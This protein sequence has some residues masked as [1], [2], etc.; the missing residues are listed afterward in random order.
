MTPW[1]LTL[2]SPSTPRPVELGHSIWPLWAPARQKKATCSGLTPRPMQI[3]TPSGAIGSGWGR[4]SGSSLRWHQ[5]PQGAGELPPPHVQGSGGTSDSPELQLH[6]PAVQQDGGGLVV[7][8]CERGSRQLKCQALPQSLVLV[9]GAG[10]RDNLMLGEKGLPTG[11]IQ[12][13]QGS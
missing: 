4:S 10:Q 6:P 13:S 9:K 12:R 3:S 11:G 8:A 5:S 2:P 7:D 1:P